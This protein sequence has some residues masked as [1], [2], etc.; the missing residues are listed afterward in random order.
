MSSS[1]TNL[2][3]KR[4]FVN[5]CK[6]RKITQIQLANGVNMTCQGVNRWFDLESDT[7]PNL[8]AIQWL[9]EQ[10]D[11]DFHW[12]MTG[13]IDPY[14]RIADGKELFDMEMWKIYDDLKKTLDK[15]A[16]KMFDYDD[17]TYLVYKEKKNP[18]EFKKH[19]EEQARIKEFREYYWK[20][21][22]NQ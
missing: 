16:L 6:D 5:F 19:R 21:N 12:L 9:S 10:Y 14:R 8:F 11:L 7:M 2:E 15:L 13:D 22:E 17:P 18:E 3:V 20:K 1:A 4:R